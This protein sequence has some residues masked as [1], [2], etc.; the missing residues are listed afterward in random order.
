MSHLQQ[1]V[2]ELGKGFAFVVR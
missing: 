1:F 2:M